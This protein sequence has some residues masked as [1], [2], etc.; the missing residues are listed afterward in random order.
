MG[1]KKQVVLLP[2]FLFIIGC[3]AF[4]VV[5]ESP[6][7][8]ID[9]VAIDFETKV[10]DHQLLFL[11]MAGHATKHIGQ[12]KYLFFQKNLKLLQLIC[13]VMANRE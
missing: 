12:S 2:F 4:E 13:L 11:Y 8:S 5:P 1:V 3:A 9:G 6:V 10:K 7:A